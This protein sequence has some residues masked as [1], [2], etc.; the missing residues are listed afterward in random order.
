MPVYNLIEYID[1]FSKTS[2]NLC[3]YRGDAPNATIT[4]SEPSNH[5]K[6]NSKSHLCW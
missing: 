4:G 1:H 3:H 6:N 5:G 2:G